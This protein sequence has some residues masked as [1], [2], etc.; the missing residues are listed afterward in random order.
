MQAGG[1]RSGNQTLLIVLLV[2]GGLCALCGVGTLALVG[3][4]VVAGAAE[5]PVSAPSAAEARPGVEGGFRMTFPE[6]F[7]PVDEARHRFERLEGSARHT[8]DVIK[9]APIDGLD[10]PQGKL[11]A[12]WNGTIVRDWPGIPTLTL[13][14]R[15][16]V[17][18]GARAFYTFAVVRVPGQDRRSMVSLYLVEAGDR[19][20]PF[21]VVQEFFDSGIGAD[22]MNNLSFDTTHPAVEAFLK[23]VE[24]SPVGLP[25]VADDEL[26]GRWAFSTGSL[27]QYVN[28]ITGGTSS[29]TVSYA[30]RYELGAD[31]RFAYRFQ[32][33]TMGAAGTRFSASHD[34][35]TWA[36]QHDLLVLDGEQFD[37]RYLIIGAGAGPD[38]KRVI[39]LQPE[40]KWSLTPAAIAQGGEL[41]E[42]ADD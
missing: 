11:R 9:L 33:A 25:L 14:L 35:G 27:G 1:G 28:V 3:L 30:V 7:K 4:G 41:Y 40:G 21:A 29:E 12:L 31:R 37:T 26:T 34:E 8:V 22:F 16:F 18:N 2:V 15:R 36:V 10:D 38:G 42:E 24:G 17:Q 23:G 13:P 32:G 19:L 6:D 5:G 39:Y 20:E